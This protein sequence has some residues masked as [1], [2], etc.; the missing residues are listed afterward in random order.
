VPIKAAYLRKS[1]T[2]GQARHWPACDCPLLP[3]A[4]Q[5]NSS[6]WMEP[7]AVLLFQNAKQVL[8]PRRGL[9]TRATST[10]NL[11][12]PRPTAQYFEPASNDT[13]PPSEPSSFNGFAEQRKQPTFGFRRTRTTSCSSAAMI[14]SA[15]ATTNTANSS[16]RNYRDITKSF[17]NSGFKY[18]SR[19][20]QLRD[21]AIGRPRSSSA[22]A[23]VPF[24]ALSSSATTLHQGVRDADV[25][26]TLANPTNTSENDLS[27]LEKIIGNEQANTIR[28][29]LAENEQTGSVNTKSK[30]NRKYKGVTQFWSNYIASNTPI[31][32]RR[33]GL[34]NSIKKP[35]GRNNHVRNIYNEEE[36]YFFGVLDGHG[37]G[38]CADVVAK[39]IGDYYMTTQVPTDEIKN[40]LLI[41][42]QQVSGK[43]FAPRLLPYRSRNLF[44]D[45]VTGDRTYPTGVNVF[46]EIWPMWRDSL[47]K[48][49]WDIANDVVE[50]R[51]DIDAVYHTMNRLDKDLLT[52]AYIYGSKDMSHVWGTLRSQ[53]REFFRDVGR[54]GCVGSVALIKQG[55]LTLGHLGDTRVVLGCKDRYRG[56]SADRITPDHSASNDA[57]A[58]KL[59]HDHPDDDPESVVVD[60]RVLGVLQPSRAFG[61]CR[62]KLPKALLAQMYKGKPDYKVFPNY[63]SPPYVSNKPLVKSI[64]LKPEIKF[65]VIASDGFWEKFEPKFSDP[66][67]SSD[68]RTQ[69]EREARQAKTEQGIIEQI[70]HHMDCLEILEQMDGEY[71]RSRFKAM[72]GLEN[73]VA[74]NIIKNCLMINEFGDSSK[75]NLIE[76]LNLH[77]SERRMRRDDIT[78]TIVKVG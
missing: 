51:D 1:V 27:G 46:N 41:A 38:H 57:E 60:G 59:M 21:E 68:E 48:F 31:E 56:W 37:G 69:E 34:R 2:A 55:M 50:I 30:R 61:D 72:H 7:A 33:F 23:H 6:P 71:E 16:T 18:S 65:V 29:D 5:R 24:R 47:H 66:V 52:E 39:R 11:C 74:T 8:K 49:A 53:T 28:A 9:K 22:A 14:S 25:M 42:S 64:P 44:N 77:P 15:Q 63:D 13:G 26:Y 12:P 19:I 54:T 10:S 73:N 45:R 78:V 75:M 43:T 36:S 20:L 3:P 35:S 40:Y 32:D 76:T 58:A 70:G 62:L 67:F 4:A 17:N